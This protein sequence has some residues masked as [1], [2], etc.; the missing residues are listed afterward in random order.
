LHHFNV[1]LDFEPFVKVKR[2]FS[3]GASAVSSFGYRKKRDGSWVKKD[4]L[5]QATEDRSPSPPP[6]RDDSSPLM[7]SILDR[8]D[9]PLIINSTPLL[10]Y[11]EAT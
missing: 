10:N 1:P 5:A 11:S 7:Q 4:A 9:G 3:I 2:S 8:L 6:Q